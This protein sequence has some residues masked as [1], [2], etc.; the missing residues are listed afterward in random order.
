MKQV[1]AIILLCSAIVLV[2]SRLSCPDIFSKFC[3]GEDFYHAAAHGIHSLTLQELQ[4][5]F[6]ES[7]TEDNDIP[8][9]N[10]DLSSPQLILPSVPDIKLNN[11]FLTP[12]MNSVDHILSNWE[13]TAFFM[14]EASVLEMLVHNLHMYETLR[15][16]IKNK[17]IIYPYFTKHEGE[18]VKLTS[19]KFV[20]S[21][22]R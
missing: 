12:S 19:K 17:I 15:K 3:V 16:G 4:Y 9:V 6:D 2:N 20:H 7:A 10:F 11:S 13:N 8:M 5:F 21:C 22:I 14:S 1:T 18:L